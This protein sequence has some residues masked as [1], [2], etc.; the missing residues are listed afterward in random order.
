MMTWREFCRRAVPV[1]FLEHGRDYEGWDCWGLV[2]CAYRDVLG[3]DLPRYDADYDST[4]DMR[5]LRRIFAAECNAIYREIPCR[6]G[7][8]ALIVRRRSEVHV[9]VVV[10][11][12]VLHTEADIGTVL[13]PMAAVKTTSY[14]TPAWI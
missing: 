8:V 6:T 4:T 9:G 7:A 2:W 12:D 10:N 13:E 14:W 11:R 3:I 5:S 1:P